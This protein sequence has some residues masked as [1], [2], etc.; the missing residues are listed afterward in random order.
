MIAQVGMLFDLRAFRNA[1]LLRSILVWMGTRVALAFGGVL[2]PGLV[3]EA[4]LVGILPAVVL[5]DARRRDEDLFLGNLG[6]PAWSVA[7]VA[8]PMVALLEVLVP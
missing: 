7:A 2:D 1:Y 3:V 5:F 4:S 8:A 6:I